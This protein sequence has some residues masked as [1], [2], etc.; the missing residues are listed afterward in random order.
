MRGVTFVL[1]DFAE[2]GV[3]VLHHEVVGLFVL[4]GVYQLHNVGTT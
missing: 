4:E 2:V 1:D 3:A